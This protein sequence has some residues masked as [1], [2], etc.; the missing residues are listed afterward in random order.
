VIANGAAIIANGA[1]ISANGAT[2]IGCTDS[3]IA[4]KESLTATV[5][6]AT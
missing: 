5:A 3:R 6:C 1:T 4:N 2:I